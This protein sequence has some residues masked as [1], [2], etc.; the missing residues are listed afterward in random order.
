MVV[1]VVRIIIITILLRKDR[2]GRRL[3][4]LIPHSLE[5]PILRNLEGLTPLSLNDLIPLNL[6]DPILHNPLELLERLD[7][8]VLLGGRTI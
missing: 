4:D 7:L 6:E 1:E 5:G 3:A 8:W 2:V